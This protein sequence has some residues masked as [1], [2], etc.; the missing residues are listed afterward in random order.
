MS[1]QVLFRGPPRLQ[2]TLTRWEEAMVLEE[3]HDQGPALVQGAPQRGVWHLLV[4]QLPEHILGFRTWEQHR[5][6]SQ[7]YGSSLLPA[8]ATIWMSVQ[9]SLN[10]V[11]QQSSEKAPAS[12]PH[13]T[14]KPTL[15]SVTG[16]PSPSPPCICNSIAKTPPFLK[17][18][19]PPQ[20][21]LPRCRHL[22]G[23]R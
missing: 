10:S 12:G 20:L 3:L 15:P 11:T 21:C 6:D 1:R 14:L 4:F 23:Q 8:P 22:Y 19:G 13:Q 5:E 18:L 7:G 2:D 16:C 17:V 9:P